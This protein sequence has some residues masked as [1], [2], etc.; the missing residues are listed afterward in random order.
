MA[1]WLTVAFFVSEAECG[2]ACQNKQEQLLLCVCVWLLLLLS[3]P[4]LQTACA[5]TDE[6]RD[7]CPKHFCIDDS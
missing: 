4:I 1:G 2:W 3:P 5:T 7:F 6:V